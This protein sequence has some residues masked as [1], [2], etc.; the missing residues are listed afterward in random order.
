[1][2]SVTCEISASNEPSL[3]SFDIQVSVQALIICK[4]RGRIR[5]GQKHNNLEE[6]STCF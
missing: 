5:H 1:M 3:S 2:D 6:A 4:I